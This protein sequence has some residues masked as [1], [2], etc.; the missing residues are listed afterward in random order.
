M[1]FLLSPLI[2]QGSPQSNVTR[3]ENTKWSCIADEEQRIISSLLHLSLKYCTVVL[4]SLCP[5]S[6]CPIMVVEVYLTWVS[7]VE[8]EA[9][10]LVSGPYQSHLP[11]CVRTAV[12]FALAES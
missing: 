6:T 7:D 2:E 1:D 12:G 4:G 5:L 10:E 11:S 9:Q 8:T 3:P